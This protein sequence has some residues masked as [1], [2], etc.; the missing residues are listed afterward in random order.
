M[1]NKFNILKTYYY[2]IKE[3]KLNFTKKSIKP[4]EENNETINRT[5]NTNNNILK[6]DSFSRRSETF[7]SIHYSAGS[8]KILSYFFC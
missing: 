3:C 2:H 6:R 7:D 8:L 5:T 1:K 4:N